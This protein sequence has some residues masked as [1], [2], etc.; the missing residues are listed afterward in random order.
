VLS[1]SPSANTPV[2]ANSEV[3]I[4]VGR[5]REPEPPPGDGGGDG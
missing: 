4:V 5:F 3:T 1:Q 2:D